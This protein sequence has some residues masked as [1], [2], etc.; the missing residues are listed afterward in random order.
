VPKAIG[1]I[2]VLAMIALAICNAQCMASCSTGVCPWDATNATDPPCHQHRPATGNC[3]HP[4]PVFADG[5]S[6]ASPI[7]DLCVMAIAGKTADPTVAASATLGN[8]VLTEVWSPPL[9]DRHS[10]LRI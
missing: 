10:I 1:K 4:T 9:T 7:P 5:V 8:A 3:A 6:S 2:A